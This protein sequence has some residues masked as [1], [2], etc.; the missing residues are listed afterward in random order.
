[1]T[2]LRGNG[3]N[4]VVLMIV[5]GSV[6]DGEVRVTLPFVRSQAESMEKAG[7]MVVYGVVDDRT[8]PSGVMRNAKKLR[9]LARRVE[10]SLVHAQYGS[11][12]A[13]LAAFVAGSLPLVVSFCGDDLLGT[14]IPT[15]KWRVRAGA[16]RRLGLLAAARAAAI[17]VKSRNL[18]EALPG[19][20]RR[21]AVILPNGVDTEWFR[22]LDHRACRLTLGW[23]PEAKVVLFHASRGEDRW[24]KNPALAQAVVDIVG[25]REPRVSLVMISDVTREEVQLML[26]AADCLLVTSLQEGSP[27]MVKEAM[28]CNLPVVSVPCGDIPERLA[29]TRPGTLCPYDTEALADALL[30]VLRTGERSNGREQIYLQGLT[31]SHVAVRLGEVYQRV[32][33]REPAAAVGA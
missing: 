14:P 25:R 17:V 7:W 24:R 19:R 4:G 26:N 29:S 1:M 18:F 10:P 13:A 15:V 6:E 27:N 5:P 30:E 9:A 12:T 23:D 3:Q 2:G 11:M 20:L 28:A 33:S 31:A 16:A 22:P 21:R 32:L 8:S